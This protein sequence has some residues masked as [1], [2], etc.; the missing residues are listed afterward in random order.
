M[1]LGGQ[2]SL[3]N[4]SLESKKYLSICFSRIYKI[5]YV[6]NV[7]KSMEQH[8]KCHKIPLRIRIILHQEIQGIAMFE[9]QL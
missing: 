4:T 2:C 3:L 1:A 5:Y 9:F 7:T 8:D 6:T